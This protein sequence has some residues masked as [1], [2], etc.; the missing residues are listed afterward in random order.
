MACISRNGSRAMMFLATLTVAIVPG[1]ALAQRN[2]KDQPPGQPSK[3]F[4]MKVQ[5]AGYGPMNTLQVVD[6]D[7]RQYLARVEYPRTSVSVK[8]EADASFLG[9]GMAVRFRGSIADE[10]KG[11]LADE[12]GEMTVFTPRTENA[13]GVEPYRGDDEKP[14]ELEFSAQLLS[15][16][17]GKFQA[18]AGECVVSG[19]LADDVKVKLHLAD[20]TVVPF[21]AE[22][23]VR[24]QLFEPNQVVCDV[25]EAT[26]PE[27][28]GQTTK[29]KRPRPPAKGKRAAKE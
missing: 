21:G 18:Q 4:D 1:G 17:K 13:F 24:G 9:P 26:L 3:P 12:V 7:Q 22:L 11:T 28:V 27:P 19:K 29:K 8:G 5:L 16:K 14:G 15:L 20:L 10:K 25:V 2:K 6:Q 23:H